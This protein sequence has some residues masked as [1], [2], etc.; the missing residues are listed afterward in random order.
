MAPHD[1]ASAL[2]RRVFEI[3]EHGTMGDATGRLLNVAL[4]GLIVI[5]VAA[6]PLNTVPELSTRYAVLFRALEVVSVIVFTLEYALR[7]W[8]AVEHAGGDRP[9][10]L[11]PSF[12]RRG[13]RAPARSPFGDRVRHGPNAVARP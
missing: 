11:A 4:V 8:V 13:R 10:G 5:N 1:K 9:G 7:L 2:R 6:V 12:L 3:L